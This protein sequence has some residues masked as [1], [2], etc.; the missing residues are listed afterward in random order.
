MKALDHIVL[1]QIAGLSQIGEELVALIIDIGRNVMRDLARGVAQADLLIIGAG[2]HPDGPAVGI[3]LLR[4]PEAHVMALA[5]IVSD[6]LLKGQIL[7]AAEQIQVADRC[8]VVVPLEDRGARHP[9]TAAQSHGIGRI[10]L[11]RQH[12]LF[13]FP[14]GADQRGVERIAGDVAARLGDARL[15][16]QRRMMAS[17]A[18]PQ[19][20][21]EE[22]SQQEIRAEQGA[23][24]DQ[25][26]PPR[27]PGVRFLGRRLSR[28]GRADSRR[29][30]G[31][32][33]D[34][35][36]RVGC[37]RH[38][39]TSA[40]RAAGGLLGNRGSAGASRAMPTLYEMP[41]EMTDVSADG[42][43]PSRPISAS[44]VEDADGR[45][46]CRFPDTIFPNVIY[47]TGAKVD[48]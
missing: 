28:P 42:A 37:T 1:L 39:T 8:I 14:L 29:S 44:R 25:D 3:D 33:L 27:M 41:G 26:V 40:V 4:L 6:R 34:R 9:Q 24:E 46:W 5:R 18:L 48:C 32:L 31:G 15:V 30:V 13:D 2:A 19:R 17:V 20:R 23:D 22:V 38:G 47:P 7:L 36:E 43:M 10:P 21:H 35:R 12:D 11:G 45:K 16:V